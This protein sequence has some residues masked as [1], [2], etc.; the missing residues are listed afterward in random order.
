VGEIE[1]QRADQETEGQDHEHGVDRM[2][3]DRCR[4]FHAARRC[5]SDAAGSEPGDPTPVASWGCPPRQDPFGERN[6]RS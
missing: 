2:A 4:S 5:E 3:C 6:V 1:H